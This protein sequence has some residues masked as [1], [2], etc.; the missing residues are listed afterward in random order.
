MQNNN[1]FFSA[2]LSKDAITANG[3]VTHSTSQNFLLDLFFLAGASREIPENQIIT[4]LQKSWSQD[5]ILTLKLIFWAGDIREGAGERRFFRVALTFLDKHYPDVLQKVIGFVPFY[6][7]W[8]SLFHLE[9]DSV[10]RLVNHALSNGDALCAKWMPR[11]NGGKFQ[12]F[13]RKYK[14]MLEVSDRAYRKRI[15]TLSKTVEQQMSAKEWEKIIYEHVPSV[16]MNKYRKAFY[17]NDVVRVEGF[18]EKVKSGEKKINASAIF[19]H[20]IYKAAM[21][22]DREDALNAQ[23]SAL[24]DYLKDSREKILPMCDVS[25]S[26]TGTPMAISVAL[27]IYL[28]EKNK[29]IFKDAFLTFSAN[30]ELQILKGTLTE[31]MRQLNGAL[32]NQNT[33]LAHAFG[34]ILQRCLENCVAP[35][36]MPSM[37]LIIS[38]MEFDE[39]GNNQTNFE[40]IRGLYEHVGYKMPKIVF[41]NVNG[42]IGNVPV[43]NND[44]GVALVSGASPA[45]IKSVLGGELD[46]MKVVRNTLMKP[47][48][49]KISIDPRNS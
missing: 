48:Y 12:D 9:N 33:D 38:D 39:T 7:R 16:A 26:M 20:D 2:V 5:P 34:L 42:R 11:E 23:W 45:I 35:E 29:S 19:P 17:R 47:R 27:G 44:R 21:R 43:K 31:K 15:T 25:G 32:W 24:P 46:P 8:D 18:I 13:R 49:E 28:S 30:P 6:N 41:W 3:A 14:K 4:L 22:G 10:V 36:D 40:K 37:L 1:P